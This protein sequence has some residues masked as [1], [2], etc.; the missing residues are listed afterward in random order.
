MTLYTPKVAFFL[1]R[2]ETLVKTTFKKLNVAD[3][4]DSKYCCPS[5]PTSRFT[6]DRAEEIEVFV[7]NLPNE[8]SEGEIMDFFRSKGVE[9]IKFRLLKN[10]VGGVKGFG[11]FG[12]QE[13]QKKCLRLDGCDY[14]GFSLNITT[15]RA[16]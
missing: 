6:G 14:Y 1:S 3:F 8:K 12:S 7:K 2:I 15:P 10:P 9:M 5:E 4:L 13:E 16:K 11:K